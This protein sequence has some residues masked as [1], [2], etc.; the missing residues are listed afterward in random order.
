MIRERVK[1]SNGEG[2]GKKENLARK[3]VRQQG[4]TEGCA[5]ERKCAKALER[6]YDG[7][8]LSDGSK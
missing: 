5:V 8:T 7:Y 3:T 4:F 6:P 2:Y 1:H